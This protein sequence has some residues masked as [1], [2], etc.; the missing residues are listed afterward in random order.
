M[1]KGKHRYIY[2]KN[3][4]QPQS[5]TFFDEDLKFMELL[6]SK[7]KDLVKVKKVKDDER[8]SV[9][10][11][12]CRFNTGVCYISRRCAEKPLSISICGGMN[13]FKSHDS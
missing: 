7:N 5:E 4:A 13:F 1:S 9:K 11:P 3:L 2:S 8:G 6:L 12:V 10:L